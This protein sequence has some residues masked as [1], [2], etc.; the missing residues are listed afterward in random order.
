MANVF[1][2]VVIIRI[3]NKRDIRIVTFSS[4]SLIRVFVVKCNLIVVIGYGF[5]WSR[6]RLKIKNVVSINVVKNNE[7]VCVLYIRD[8]YKMRYRV[9]VAR[10]LFFF[11]LYVYLS[12][13]Y[14][15]YY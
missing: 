11:I 13:T 10:V 15:C 1:I 5:V 7:V 12:M 2:N 8:V 6:K 14:L 9:R 4:Y 3:G